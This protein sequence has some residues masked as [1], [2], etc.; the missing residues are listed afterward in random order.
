MDRNIEVMNI[1]WEAF[2][3]SLARMSTNEQRPFFIGFA[4]EMNKYPTEYQRDM[5]LA[6]IRMG[7]D[8]DPFT[9]KQAEVFRHLG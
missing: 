2:G 3:A 8:S 7:M 9:E 4:N 5:Q 1:N 6:H